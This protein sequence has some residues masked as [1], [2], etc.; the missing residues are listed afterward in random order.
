MVRMVVVG[1]LFVLPSVLSPFNKSSLSPSFILRPPSA[2]SDVLLFPCCPGFLSLML[3]QGGFTVRLY[4]NIRLP[5]CESV[6][7]CSTEEMGISQITSDEA[8]LI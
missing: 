2:R 6:I 4:R 8:N 5:S 3:R 1:F 7:N